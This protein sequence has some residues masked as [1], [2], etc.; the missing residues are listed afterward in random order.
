MIK[1]SLKLKLFCI[2]YV[3][4]VKEYCL[5]LHERYHSI[6]LEVMLLHDLIQLLLSNIVAYFAHGIDDVVLSNCAG[7]ICVKL[8]EY[9]QEHPVVQKLFHI[10]S[11][12]KE[13]SVIYF[14]VALVIHFVYYLVYFLIR[15]VDVTCL[16]SILELSS[17]YQT[18]TVFI[19]GN[20][21]FSQLF[22]LALIRHLYQHIHSCLL[23]LTDTLKRLQARYDIFVN[24]R[25]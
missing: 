4:H 18:C 14:A 25:G 6:I 23:Q 17:I 1:S 21:F 8:V 5:E 12:N 7:A 11:C 20:E 10:Q 16:N 24:Q 22:N 19:D 15:D 9:C 2:L 13:L 3:F